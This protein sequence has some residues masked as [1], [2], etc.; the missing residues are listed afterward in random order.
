MNLYSEESNID[1][2]Y[3]FLLPPDKV[4]QDLKQKGFKLLMQKGLDAGKG[5]KDD[6]KILKPFL[7]M[8]YDSS[9]FIPRA[10]MYGLSLTLQKFC[11]HATLLVMQKKA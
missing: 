3:Q 9:Y 7:Q 11:P 10:F 6:V 1:N 4:A 8:C 2:F 5:L